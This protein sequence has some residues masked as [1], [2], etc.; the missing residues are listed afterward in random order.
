ML[1]DYLNF[2]APL[3]SIDQE[4]ANAPLSD[5]KNLE[6]KRE[7]ILNSLYKN[8]DDWQVTQ[9]ARHPDRA[10][11]KDVIDAIT[12]TRVSL[13][14]DRL[15][16]KCPATCA[17]IAKIDSHPVVIVAQQKGRSIQERIAHQYGMPNPCGYRLAMRA[18]ELAKRYHYPIITLIDTPGAFPGIEGEI[19]NQS[20]AISEN[21]VYLS[22]VPTPVINII[23]GEGMSGGALGIGVG[24]RMAMYQNSIF[25]VIS[26]EGCAAILWK[27]AK[28]AKDA[29]HKMQITAN[30][31]IG[32]NLIDDIISEG[33]Y[34]AAH[35][36]FNGCFTATKQ[37][38]IE[39]IKHLK[40]LPTDE[41][42]KQREQK[43]LQYGSC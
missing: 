28:K 5:Q 19:Q 34:G 21:L 26:P 43:L 12:D 2:E 30:R 8:L 42:L 10:H 11:A 41:L 9:L 1:S 13:S 37:Y 38:I 27:D 24:D 36:D 33:K 35:V 22:Q 3:Q 23:I 14:G 6:R 15:T 16:G 17:Y 29:C 18:F 31:L 7:K 39:Q 4:I 20:A 25:S 40:A 32:H